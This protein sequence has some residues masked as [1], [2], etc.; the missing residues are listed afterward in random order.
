MPDSGQTNRWDTEKRW[1]QI[2][3]E[4]RGSYLILEFD[5]ASDAYNAIGFYITHGIRE[6]AEI[7]YGVNKQEVVVVPRSRILTVKQIVFDPT[8]L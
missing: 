7:W 2:E 5:T 6:F 4:G 3:I 1:V 8:S